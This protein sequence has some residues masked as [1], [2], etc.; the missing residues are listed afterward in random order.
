VASRPSLFRH[1][2]LAFQ[3]Q[4]RR[5]GE[6]VL[7]QPLPVTVMAW[8]VTV[9]MVLILIVL[10]VAQYARKETVRGYLT[11]TAGTAKIF[12]PRPGTVRAVH[13]TEGQPVREGQPLLTIAT[14]QIAAD[15]KDV[16]AAIMETLTHQRG[17]LARQIA[18]QEERTA[19]ERNRLVA[20]IGGLEAESAHLRDQIA[21][22]EERIRISEDLV[23]AAARL[24]ARGNM[25]ESEY[26]E[27]QE[28][29]LQQKLA[30]SILGQRLAEHWNR[31]TET[32]YTL[33]QLPVVMAE[34]I[35]DLRNELS[36]AEQRIAEIN[37]R[38]AYVL[39]APNAG[40]VAT[41]QATAGRTADPRGARQRT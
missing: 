25:P 37:G 27:R 22:Q 38:R 4:Q 36:Q 33:E 17:L 18:A 10:S 13:V 9:S 32:R 15:G 34:R 6:V 21:I 41:L 26:R 7:L 35:Q 11:P 28:S 39:Q 3:Q 12:P 40:R 1:E 16:D 23:Q 8:F 19:S 20:L 30:L 14:D 31:L 5:W 2:A 29:N 24:S